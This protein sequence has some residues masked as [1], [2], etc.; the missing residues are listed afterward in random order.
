[1]RFL[2]HLIVRLVA[3]FFGLFVAMLAASL[4]L[5]AGIFGGMASDF[6]ADLQWVIEG[7]PYLDPADTSPLVTP[8][9]VLLATG[10]VGGFFYWLI[11]GRSAGKW[12][13]MPEAVNR[14]P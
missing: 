11:A 3:V 14:A 13:D 9:V 2:G 5:S 8:L 6:L 7:D 12:L 10:F 4:F 1:M